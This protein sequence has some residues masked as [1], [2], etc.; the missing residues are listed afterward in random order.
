[1]SFFGTEMADQFYQEGADSLGPATWTGKL[2]RELYGDIVPV[3]WVARNATIL[4]ALAGNI[5][6]LVVISTIVSRANRPSG[7]G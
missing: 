5:Y 7:N 3:S 2:L 1:M 4:A 6:S